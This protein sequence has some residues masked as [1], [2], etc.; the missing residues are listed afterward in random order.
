M[1]EEE[2]PIT[3]TYVADIVCSGSS[4]ANIGTTLK[5]QISAIR[6]IGYALKAPQPLIGADQ[7][8]SPTEAEIKSC[9]VH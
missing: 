5:P 2:G 7:I 6:K 9:D 1:G 4:M 8:T 3:M